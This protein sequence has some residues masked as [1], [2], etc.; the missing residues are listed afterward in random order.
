LFLDVSFPSHGHIYGIPE[1][2]TNLALPSTKGEGSKYSD[3]YRLYNADVFEY[4]ADSPMTLY[5]AIPLLHAHSDQST[6]G[7][8]NLIASETWIDVWYPS[9]SSA[10]THWLS[11]SGVM[12]LFIFP[13]PTADDIFAQYSRLTGPPVLPAEWALGYHQCR[14]NYMTSEDVRTVQRRLDEEDMPFDVIWLDIEHAEDHKYFI[15]NDKTFPDPVEMINDLEAVGRKVR[16]YTFL[17]MKY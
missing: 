8:F 10:K 5:G 17:S 16:F 2:A 7:F 15:W 11:E 1:H 3:P 14:W 9:K 4:E 12:D 6:V 13:G